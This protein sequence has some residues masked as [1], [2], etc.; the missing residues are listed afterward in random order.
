[1]HI[2]PWEVAFLILLLLGVILISRIVTH[3]QTKRICP[4]CGLAMHIH[5]PSCP[6]CGRNLTLKGKGKSE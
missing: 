1:M 5:L 4:D 6:S 3:L 2:G